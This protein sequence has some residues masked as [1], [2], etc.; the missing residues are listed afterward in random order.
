MEYP[1]IYYSKIIQYI[2]LFF[3]IFRALW[4]FVAERK[5]VMS[6]S[7][8]LLPHTPL[9]SFVVMQYA[10]WIYISIEAA[11]IITYYSQ[12][13][14]YLNSTQQSQYV[15][16]KQL[17]V[18][19]PHN[20]TILIAVIKYVIW[21][22]TS[23]EAADIIICTLDLYM[24]RTRGYYKHQKQYTSSGLNILAIIFSYSG[25]KNQVHQENGLISYG[26]I[27][28]NYLTFTFFTK[29]VEVHVHTSLFFTHSK[30]VL[31]IQKNKNYGTKLLL[32]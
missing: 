3:S 5:P 27:I 2:V 18:L 30:K 10:L 29:D 11:V 14:N 17:Y 16:Q 12:S 32:K 4:A 8:L 13:K 1:R 6:Q 20:F 24:N 26:L 9:L 21:I 15:Q 23:I 31:P 7:F 19:N 25:H 22:Y 28:R